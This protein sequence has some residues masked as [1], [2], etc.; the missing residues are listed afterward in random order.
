[1]AIL[2]ADISFTFIPVL[3]NVLRFNKT[4][5]CGFKKIVVGL[6][7]IAVGCGFKKNIPQVLTTIKTLNL[8]EAI[9]SDHELK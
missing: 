6:K 9:V 7:K 2:E 1:M 4:V 3:N 8:C 5:D